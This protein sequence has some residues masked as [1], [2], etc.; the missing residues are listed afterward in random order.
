MTA[1][2]ILAKRSVLEITD[3][4]YVLILKLFR[5]NVCHI[6]QLNFCLFLSRV[7]YITDYFYRFLCCCVARK[8]P[9]C[10]EFS[11]NKIY[12]NF[13]LA[14]P[15]VL[16]MEFSKSNEALC[17]SP[18]SGFGSEHQYS[19]PD[20]VINEAGSS[21]ND[22]VASASKI[23]FQPVE[24]NDDDQFLS[25]LKIVDVKSLAVKSL[26]QAA[27]ENFPSEAKQLL[28]LS[29]CPLKGATKLC[30]Q[31]IGNKK[32]MKL[33]TKLSSHNCINISASDFGFETS[34][35][36]VEEQLYLGFSGLPV[37]SNR[38]A[39]MLDSKKRDEFVLSL[40]SRDDRRRYSSLSAATE[41]FVSSSFSTA[42]AV[43]SIK[44]ETFEPIVQK[45]NTPTHQCYTPEPCISGEDLHSSGISNS[46]IAICD[47]P[48]D[49]T[50]PLKSEV[51]DRK[52]D[53]IRRLKEIIL[54][55]EKN[56][57]AVRKNCGFI[58]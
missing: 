1:E 7:S 37:I 46:G 40:M 38:H 35:S 17:C 16:V 24:K 13:C 6:P 41:N 22:D 8:I 42:D 33:D 48:L 19:P 3:F 23:L 36:D 57:Q 11:N 18:E 27:E 52:A 50:A 55:K 5:T 2:S 32:V 10:N 34:V 29:P 31:Q 4:I 39:L 58:S 54:Q 9:V 49:K 15:A 43:V 45:Q 26:N 51:T 56:L 28:G 12:S 14:E 53:R 25:C 30:L 44:Q 21:G 47:A 20:S